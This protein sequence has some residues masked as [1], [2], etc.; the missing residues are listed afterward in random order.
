MGKLKNHVQ[1]ALI[2]PGITASVLR[3]DAGGLAHG[4]DVIAGKH[5]PVHFL[6]ELMHPG[7]VDRMGRKV[8]VE[9][10]EEHIKTKLAEFLEKGVI[11]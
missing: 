1:L 2:L 11:K 8:A 10:A 5:L 7:A 9:R 4:H 6:Q 3:R